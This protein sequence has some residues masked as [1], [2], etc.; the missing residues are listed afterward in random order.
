MSLAL[1][2]KGSVPAASYECAR[3][4]WW[5][6][7]A[8]FSSL[9]SG[10]N[11]CSQSRRLS[12]LSLQSTHKMHY[13]LLEASCG[14]LRARLGT[15]EVIRAEFLVS[16]S[17]FKTRSAPHS[18]RDPTWTRS[19]RFQRSCGF[20]VVLQKRFFFLNWLDQIISIIGPSMKDWQASAMLESSATRW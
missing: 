2:K 14:D 9:P 1:E 17:V 20:W 19:H 12:L 11:V 13:C 6:L 15:L 4:R 16:L 10:S 3:D 8:F 5:H 18:R 7:F